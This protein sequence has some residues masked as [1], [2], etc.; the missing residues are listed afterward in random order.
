MCVEAMDTKSK[1]LRNGCQ[2]KTM[3]PG[4]TLRWIRPRVFAE[5]GEK[6]D[7]AS[8]QCRGS[9]L[10]TIRKYLGRERRR[11]QLADLAQLL[12]GI[13][14][15]ANKKESTREARLIGACAHRQPP[16]AMAPENTTQYLM[17]NVYEDMTTDGIHAVPRD[18]SADVYCGSLSSRVC[19]PQ[20]CDEDGCLAFQQRDFEEVFALYW[21]P[22]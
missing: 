3:K 9:A 5:E 22:E 2:R 13:G 19:A 14:G 11:P 18:A 4:S 8:K 15:K 10:R 21:Q 17:G 6:A 20:D 1:N 12:G 7:E 16:G